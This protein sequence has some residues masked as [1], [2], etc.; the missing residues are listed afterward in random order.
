MKKKE[1]NAKLQEIKSSEPL[2]QDLKA[3]VQN[4]VS[5]VNVEVNLSELGG[6][7]KTDPQLAKEYLEIIRANQAHIQKN[8]YRRKSNG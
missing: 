5:S 2:P 8:G 4:N 7:A 3:I 6:L 1:I